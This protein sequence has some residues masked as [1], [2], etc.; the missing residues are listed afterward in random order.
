[1]TESGAELG[2]G[3]LP[4]FSP[5]KM[6]HRQILVVF[7]ALGLGMLLAALDQTI[8]STALWT[9][10]KD[11]GG[12]KGLEH[13]SWVVT[14]Y[15]LTSTASTPLYGKISDLY[16]RKR[17]YMFAITMFLLGSMLAGLSQN[18]WQLIGTRA[19]QGIGAGGLM[20][21]TFA[22]IGDVVSPRERGRYQ[23]YFGGVFA[24][25]SVAGPLLGGFFTDAHSLFGIHT[26]WR[27]V[28]YINL[29]L[30]LLALV[31][32]SIVLNIPIERR[33]HHVDFLGAALLV[34][35]V[36]A[37]LLVTVWGGQQYAWG[38][39][40]ILGL[41]GGA[42][43]LIALFGWHE[44]RESEPIVPL[45]LFANRVVSVANG[46][47]FIIG[48]AM[49]GAIIFLPLYLQIVDGATP[50]ESGLRLLPFMAG[51]LTT[52]ITSGRLITRMGRYKVFPVAGTAVTALG[53]WLLSHLGVHTSAWVLG[54]YMFVLGM[55]LGMVMQVLVLA[56]QNA[57]SP[58]DMGVATSG[59]TF[60]RS[61]GGAF[62]TAVFG[63]ILSNRI[64]A[65][66]PHGAAAGG[67]G[68]PSPAQIKLLPPAMQHI[69]TDAYVRSLHVV[70]LSAAG[71]VFLAFILS[72]FLK[73]LRLRGHGETHAEA[74]AAAPTDRDTANV[75]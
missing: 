3:Q 28:F 48:F 25:A 17:V 29:P 43:V 50:T 4:G 34:A 69:V 65:Y 39:P 14:A 53:M 67:G 73:E 10:V 6:T 24:L 22:I 42:I 51:I 46:I 11:I 21:L 23:G 27:W 45:R 55:G 64:A 26:S 66:L 54:A 70:F 71:V 38:S 57:V 59:T 9:I 16:G 62:G 19:V 33:E 18:M 5:P 63:A 75:A 32:T 8:V 13:M 68:T 35:G 61:M 31:V 74:L 60:F 36:S 49:F 47:G 40:T 44:S 2:T 56:V 12:S 52:S 41:L 15:L 58:R 37:L 20:A 7:S 30:G 72:W 1:M